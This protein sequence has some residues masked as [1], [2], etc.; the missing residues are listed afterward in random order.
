MVDV[1][2]NIKILDF[3]ISALIDPDIFSAELKEPE[4]VKPAKQMA[5]EPSQAL[6]QPLTTET[7]F[8]VSEK[9]AVELLNTSSPSHTAAHTR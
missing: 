9:V 5:S 6:A 4:H 1:N 2:G 3:G 7:M 8:M